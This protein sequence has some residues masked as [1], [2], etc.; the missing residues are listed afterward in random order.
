M[1]EELATAERYYTKDSD[2]Y[3]EMQKKKTAA[4]LAEVAARNALS[5]H[6]IQQ[7]PGGAQDQLTD[8]AIQQAN[9]AAARQLDELSAQEEIARL[10]DLKDQEY[11]IKLD[12]LKQELALDGLTEKAKLDLNDKI[13]N[14]NR[15]Q[16]QTTNQLLNQE[17]AARSAA[18]H[19]WVAPVQSALSGMT[20]GILQGTLTWRKAEQ[21]AA[22]AVASSYVNML[23][24]RAMNY[25]HTHVIMA[26]YDALF[27]ARAVAAT[28]ATE[29]GKTGATAGGVV[30]RQAAQAPEQIGFLA[31]L[32]EMLLGWLER[33]S[34]R[35]PVPPH[36]R[37][38]TSLRAGP[39]RSPTSA[40]TP[41]VPPRRHLRRLVRSRS[42]AR[43]WPRRPPLPPTPPRWPLA[44]ALRCPRP[45]VA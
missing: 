29:A 10:K 26:A 6:G 27:G 44:P 8:N 32:G 36:A 17:A 30:A 9:I 24:Q 12:A 23:A 15:Q 40:P 28:A 33:P 39:W 43:P 11:Q 22:T 2:Q 1:A 14:L 41:L 21:Q 16:L 5:E 42:L 37:S 3:R 45:G 25:L 38:P 34:Q 4:D 20:Q 7:G 35:M 19:E 13:L 31:R 18:V